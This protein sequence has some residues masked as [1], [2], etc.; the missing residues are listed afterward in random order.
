MTLKSLA[1]VG[2]S[3]MAISF[4]ACHGV[5]R[6]QSGSAT[7]DVALP[8]GA[9]VSCRDGTLGPPSYR[10]SDLGKPGVPKVTGKNLVT[11]EKL[12]RTASSPTL[13]F[14]YVDG[15]FIIYDAFNG[16]CSRIVPYSVMNGACSEEY[17]PVDRPNHTFSA[18]ECF[19]KHP[20]PWSHSPRPRNT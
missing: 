13:R 1:I 7:P 2:V 12:E 5:T 4:T 17:A 11:L 3:L 15:E 14:A 18:G 6:P 10:A 19:E 20:R 9:G 8:V 16:P